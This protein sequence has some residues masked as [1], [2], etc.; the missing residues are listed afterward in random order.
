[1]EAKSDKKKK[2]KEDSR[3]GMRGSP[4]GSVLT[5][6]TGIHEDTGSIP[7]LAQW[8]GDP[9]LLWLWCRLGATAPIQPL[10]RELPYA[11][12]GAVKRRRRKRKNRHETRKSW[13]GWEPDWIR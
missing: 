13:W 8:V 6:S 1:M 4:C 12:G 7:G 5:N 11:S 2:K 10:V 3:I 9:T